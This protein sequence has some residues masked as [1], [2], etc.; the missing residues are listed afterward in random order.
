MNKKNRTKFGA[1]IINN[2]RLWKIFTARIKKMKTYSYIDEL[3]VLD[4]EISE[5][6][7]KKEF[8]ITQ[9]FERLTNNKEVNGT[10][11]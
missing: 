1:H 2:M 4:Y 6:K 11:N 7:R 10:S 3:R 5:L 8:I 9:M